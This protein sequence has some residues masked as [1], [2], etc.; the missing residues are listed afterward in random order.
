MQWKL[1]KIKGKFIKEERRG[2]QLQA[3]KRNSFSK[4]KI[5]STAGFGCHA[6]TIEMKR[7][8][9]VKV[10]KV[11]NFIFSQS[12]SL[13]RFG[14]SQTFHPFFTYLHGKHTSTHTSEMPTNKSYIL[15]HHFKR[16]HMHAHQRELKNSDGD[17]DDDDFNIE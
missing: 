10:N 7:K 5:Y 1:V 14:V 16:T 17:G 9:K 6:E 12:L 11:I 13:L 3:Q 15:I 2:K 4:F 8:S